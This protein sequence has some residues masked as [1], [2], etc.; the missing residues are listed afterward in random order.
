MPSELMRNLPDIWTKVA[1][2]TKLSA[3][4]IDVTVAIARPLIDGGNIS[5][6]KI[7]VM[8]PNPKEYA[9]TY[10]T[11]A[12]KA[13]IRRLVEVVETEQLMWLNSNSLIYEWFNVSVLLNS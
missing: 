7:Q 4:F 10:V 8:G 9:Q 11:R 6:N 1:D 5:L 2:T 13:I 12:K 3:Q